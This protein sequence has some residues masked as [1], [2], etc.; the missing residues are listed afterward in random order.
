MQQRR[1]SYAHLDVKRVLE[2]LGIDYIEKHK[3]VSK[4]W[5]GV[6]CPFCDDDSYHGGLSLT[7]GNF[8][9]WKCHETRS[10]ERIL[11]KLSSLPRSSIIT[12]LE[13][14]S[15]IIPMDIIGRLRRLLGGSDS[16]P[17]GTPECSTHDLALPKHCVP[18]QDM[19]DNELLTQFLTNRRFTQE[20]VE[21]RDCQVCTL[22]DLQHR[23]IIPVTQ[24][25]LPSGWQARDMTGWSDTKYRNPHGFKLHDYL[26]GVKPK[27]SKRV[28]LVEGVFDQWRLSGI[29]HALCTFGTSLSHRQKAT[30][31]K[32]GATEIVF[33]WDSDATDKAMKAADKLA[34]LFETRVI[35]FPEGE[36]PDSY[37][38]EKTAELIGGLIC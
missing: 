1:T 34:S 22:G 21:S 14:Q 36:D 28:V 32:M 26:Y 23:L 10:F 8:S 35:Q 27:G 2:Q 5:V 30:L 16:K 3:N 20:D 11:A 17:V 24:K 6:V 9:C 33:A 19:A 29:C 18:V 37:P 12:A 15:A 38:L 31:I 4:G 25:D 13:H 7:Y